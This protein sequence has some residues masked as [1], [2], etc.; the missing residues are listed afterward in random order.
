MEQ[1]E[2]RAHICLT[3]VL[4]AAAYRIAV[5]AKLPPI[6][7]LT[8]L[9]YYSLVRQHSPP[10]ASASAAASAASLSAPALAW[11]K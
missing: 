4:T 10:S 5:G 3:I 1:L 9:D 8:V 2:S 7:Y 11:G 6:S